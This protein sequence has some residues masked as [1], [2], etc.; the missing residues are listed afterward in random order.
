LKLLCFAGWV[1]GRARDV[2]ANTKWTIGT[3]FSW[4]ASD[5]EDYQ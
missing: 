5:F 3:P 4:G 2:T 1:V